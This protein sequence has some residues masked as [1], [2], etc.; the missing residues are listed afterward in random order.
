[1]LPAVEADVAD[2]ASAVMPGGVRIGLQRHQEANM[3]PEIEEGAATSVLV[4][5]SPLLEGVTGRYFEDC[6]EAGPN[7]PTRP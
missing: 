2:T 1:M 4:A 5:A 6:N 7:T 3:T